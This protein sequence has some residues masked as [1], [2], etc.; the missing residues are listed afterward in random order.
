[1]Q[2]FL[3]YPDFTQSAKVLDYR[4]L[5]KQRVETKQLLQ[6][7]LEET[8]K[9]G[10]RNHPAKKM[11]DGYAQALAHYGRIICLEWR[12]RGY[13][14]TLLEYFEARSQDNNPALPP[15]VGQDDF[16]K[17]HRSNLLRKDKMYYSKFFTDVDDTYPYIWPSNNDKS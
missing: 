10:W 5:G 8:D 9:K 12:G 13:K 17:A 7:I 6:I 14:D 1:M 11:W 4:R 2:T 16:H 3:P 15:W